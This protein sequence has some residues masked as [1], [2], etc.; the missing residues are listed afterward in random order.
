MCKN[1]TYASIF[2]QKS[3]YFSCFA[4]SPPQLKQVTWTVA[5]GAKNGVGSHV[6][7]FKVVTRTVNGG[8]FSDIMISGWQPVCDPQ[9]YCKKDANS[10]YIGQD[11]HMGKKQILKN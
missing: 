7:D 3:L 2:P 1:Q 11:H 5:F 9:S 4:E 8:K 6:Y 10:L